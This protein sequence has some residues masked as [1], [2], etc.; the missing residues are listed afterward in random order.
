MSQL[1]SLVKV[2]VLSQRHDGS[3]EL[4]SEWGTK[5]STFA[6]RSILEVKFDIL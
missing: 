5:H 4:E 1:C 2:I 6:K 3:S